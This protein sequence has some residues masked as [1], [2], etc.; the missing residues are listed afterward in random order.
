MPIS[1][2]NPFKWRQR[3]GEV[4]ILC[5]RWSLRYPL[6]YEHVTEL[7]ADEVSTWMPAAFGAGCRPMH[8]S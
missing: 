4:I 1:L 6:S 3:P 7:V 5:V 2:H 8:P